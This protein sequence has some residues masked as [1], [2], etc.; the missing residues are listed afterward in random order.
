VI[1]GLPGDGFGGIVFT[2]NL[3]IKIIKSIFTKFVMSQ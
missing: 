1:T 2:I 3:P